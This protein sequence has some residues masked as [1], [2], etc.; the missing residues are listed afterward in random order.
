[1]KSYQKSNIF[2]IFVLI[3]FSFSFI[4]VLQV[5]QVDAYEPFSIETP[6]GSHIMAYTNPMGC[7]A[8][9]D[10]KVLPDGLV[11]TSSFCLYIS[12]P[13]NS[14][15]RL[16]ID[17]YA[18]QTV[19]IPVYD[20]ASHG[21]IQQ[22]Q[23]SYSLFVSQYNRTVTNGDNIY[24]D[25][26]YSTYLIDKVQW[27]YLKSQLD[28]VQLVLH[29]D[30]LT[31]KFWFKTSF[32][33][34]P[35]NTTQGQIFIDAIVALVVAILLILFFSW[36]FN[37]IAKKI[38]M[39]VKYPLSV[40]FSWISVLFIFFISIYSSMRLAI[41][42]EYNSL[43]WTLLAGVNISLTAFISFIIVGHFQNQ[44]LVPFTVFEVKG[45]PFVDKAKARRDYLKKQGEMRNKIALQDSLPEQE[46]E[47][48]LPEPDKEK[49]ALK[50]VI[51]K[52]QYWQYSHKG[53]KRYLKNENSLGEMIARLFS[54][55]IQLNFNFKNP[56]IWKGRTVFGDWDTEFETEL[57]Q[58][59]FDEE[60]LFCHS[61]KEKEVGIWSEK[62]D[63]FSH[64]I[65]II[66]L[67][68]AGLILAILASFSGI[69]T[70]QKYFQV[71][72]GLLF[73]A[74]F[75]TLIIVYIIKSSGYSYQ[76]SLSPLPQDVNMSFFDGMRV[77][78]KDQETNELLEDLE[79][80][81][82]QMDSIRHEEWLRS[83]LRWN[84]E[85]YPD[86]IKNDINAKLSDAINT[87]NKYNPD[88]GNDYKSR[89]NKLSKKYYQST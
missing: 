24:N 61:F 19:T 81:T 16:T 70:L 20:P 46:E 32:S 84:N 27:S 23:T 22:N 51:L 47:W 13:D 38:G 83:Q 50:G 56:F 57:A 15:H 31:E 48:Q 72:S 11:D 59:D 62:L 55:G 80:I 44:S 87:N 29:Y 53:H 63:F 14:S 18:S 41:F 49:P 67:A 5:H 4:G 73:I 82:M 1:M 8:E 35:F 34:E 68:Y 69:F 2:A 28:K 43:G 75:F 6:L 54:K 58:S 71:F 74:F 85:R 36:F 60:F 25:S 79:T 26:T 37:R 33:N 65:P 7:N 78:Q 40:I 64:K 77:Y 10:F 89:I 30:G 3:M 42:Q 52:H 88:L 66:N 21:Y 12:N 45:V 17:M 86:N 9:G 76:I 39:W